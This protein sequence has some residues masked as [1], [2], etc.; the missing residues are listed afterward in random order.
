MKNLISEWK[1]PL[2]FILSCQIHWGQEKRLPTFFKNDYEK[3]HPELIIIT[4]QV[5]WGRRLGEKCD[6]KNIQ[7]V[8]R[9]R[10]SSGCT[11]EIRSI[12]TQDDPVLARSSM[13]CLGFR[14]TAAEPLVF[15]LLPGNRW[16]EN[17]W[18]RTYRVWLN[19]VTVYFR[20]IELQRYLFLEN[21][22]GLLFNMGFHNHYFS[23]EYTFWETASN[24]T[25]LGHT[26]L[27]NI[28]SFFQWWAY[29]LSHQVKI[30][31]KYSCS[32]IVNTGIYD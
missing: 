11:R 12:P 24:S 27:F 19:S 5:R 21:I 8:E 25:C 26:H 13:L 1:T 29:S 28:S 7:E 32:A 20:S 10:S 16:G 3:P 6:L 2:N 14:V 17:R 4:L 9:R 15:A 31:E 22:F 18:L 30:S 23:W